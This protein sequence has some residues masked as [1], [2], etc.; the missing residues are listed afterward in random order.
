M[1]QKEL[2]PEFISLFR[3]QLKHLKKYVGKRC[4]DFNI[5]CPVCQTYMA[6]DILEEF[7]ELEEEY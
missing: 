3:V 1:K 5:N 6:I 4:G 7:L 2:T